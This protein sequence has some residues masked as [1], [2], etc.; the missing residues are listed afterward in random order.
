MI[1]HRLI[2]LT[3]ALCAM[4]AILIQLQP[5][6]LQAQER[7]AGRVEYVGVDGTMA[8]ID[9][10]SGRVWVLANVKDSRFTLSQQYNQPGWQWREV[11][12]SEAT[13]PAS[14]NDED[15]VV[16]RPATK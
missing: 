5:L 16:P 11:E 14:D 9:V 3:V 12:L 8:K 10:G 4:P 7:S 1:K 13:R 6:P 15:V 2:V